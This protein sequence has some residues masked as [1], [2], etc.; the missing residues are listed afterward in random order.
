MTKKK[1]EQAPLKP[2]KKIRKLLDLDRETIAAFE[3]M[4]ALDR[5]K[6]V[7]SIMQLVLKETAS[8]FWK[9]SPEAWLL[10]KNGQD[11]EGGKR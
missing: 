9:N 4:V 1:K 10:W 11:K 3:M 8:K 7:K 6:D 2:E 5:G